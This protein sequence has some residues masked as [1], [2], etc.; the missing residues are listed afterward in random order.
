[1]E[2]AITVNL[3]TKKDN[4]MD[5]FVNS[6]V[7]RGEV[8]EVINYPFGTGVLAEDEMEKLP[9][10]FP[11]APTLYKVYSAEPDVDSSLVSKTVAIVAGVVAF[12]SGGL[13]VH[14]VL[15]HKRSK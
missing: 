10:V 9:E 2:T 4:G 14:H 15:G 12:I 8:G 6:V 11:E 3:F 13:L 5:K 7:L 1:M